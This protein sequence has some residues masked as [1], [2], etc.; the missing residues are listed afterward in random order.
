MTSRRLTSAGD[1]VCVD[2]AVFARSTA[3]GLVEPAVSPGFREDPRDVTS[4][5]VSG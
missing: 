4:S 1:D 2:L 5:D 3:S